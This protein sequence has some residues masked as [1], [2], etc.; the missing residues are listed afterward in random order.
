M[1]SPALL[2]VSLTVERRAA[3]SSLHSRQAVRSEFLAFF[4]GR[5]SFL[6]VSDDCFFF[7][8]YLL[9]LLSFLLLVPDDSLPRIPEGASYAMLELM[10]FYYRLLIFEGGAWV[11][12][13]FFLNKAPTLLE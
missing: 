10:D 8:S 12:S 2:R 13:S 11:V 5:V 7:L 4:G 1:K 6:L 9:S 3:G